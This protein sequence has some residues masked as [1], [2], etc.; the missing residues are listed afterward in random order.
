M[1]KRILVAY[2]SKCGS[3]G[4]VA[5]AIGEELRQS[6][7]SVDVRPVEDVDEVGPYDGVI[8]GGPVLYGKWKASAAKFMARH[9]GVLSRTPVACFIMCLELTSV[10][11]DRVSAVPI[12]LDPDLGKLPRVEGRLSAFEK[13]HLLSALVEP[14]LEKTPEVKPL[15]VGVFRGKL[16]YGKL[17]ALSWLVMKLIWLIYKRAPEGDF[18]NWEVIRSWAARLFAAESA[19]GRA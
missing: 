18:R 9:E 17:D 7:A 12:Y 5:E 14:M 1:N 15:S 13:G 8:V 4:E 3:T 2:A 6:G 16:D 10:S 19:A 11:D